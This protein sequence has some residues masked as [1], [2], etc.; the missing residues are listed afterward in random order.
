MQGYLGDDAANVSA[1]DEDGWLRTGDAAT[2]KQDAERVEYLFIV[3]RKMDILK[4]LHRV[5]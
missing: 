1:F 4:V 3:D 5:M 2:F